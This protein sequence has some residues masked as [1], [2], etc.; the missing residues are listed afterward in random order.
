M[1]ITKERETFNFMGLDFDVTKAKEMIEAKTKGL[2]ETTIDI[3]EMVM[4]IQHDIGP[5]GKLYFEEEIPKNIKKWSATME[6]GI[7]YE[8][9][10][11]VKVE[12]YAIGIQFKSEFGGCIIDGWHRIYKAYKT[13]IKTMKCYCFSANLARKLVNNPRMRERLF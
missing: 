5:D 10:K 4:S 11:K 8:R 13:G 12:G 7:D 9:A 2:E 6:I 3:E 1:N